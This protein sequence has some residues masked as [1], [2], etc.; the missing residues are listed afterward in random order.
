VLCLL[1]TDH[2]R[3]EG[4]APLA[5]VRMDWPPQ[6][7]RWRGLRQ[8][9]RLT[10]KA[11]SLAP[12][13][14]RVAAPMLADGY[15]R[16]ARERLHTGLQVIGAAECLVTDRL[17][18]HIVALLAGVPQVLLDNSYGKLRGFWEAWTRPASTT[19]VATLDG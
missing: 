4:R 11:A 2:E 1:R 3:V 17:H 15:E 10:G 13:V 8:A 6:G 14:A 19:S 12:P 7:R 16:L 9:T 5:G 18:A